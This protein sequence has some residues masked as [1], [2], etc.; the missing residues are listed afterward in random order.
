[1]GVFRREVSTFKIGQRVIQSKLAGETPPHLR[2]NRKEWKT[3][4]QEGQ[5]QPGSHHQLG[6]GGSLKGP[7]AVCNRAL[8]GALLNKG[9]MELRGQV[10]PGPWTGKLGSSNRR[11]WR[12]KAER[13]EGDKSRSKRWTGGGAGG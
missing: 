5:D 11:F 9:A 10:R 12:R 8:V 2:E 6:E 13:E 4:D 3:V 7:T 1:M